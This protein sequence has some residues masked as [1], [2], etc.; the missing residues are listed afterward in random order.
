MP[1][2]VFRKWWFWTLLALL[3]IAIFITFVVGS[4]RER[5]ERTLSDF[6]ANARAGIVTKVEVRDTE[7]TYGLEGDDIT[8]ETHMEEGDAVREILRDAGLEPGDPGYPRIEISRTSRLGNIIGIIL[9]FVPIILILG[10]LYYFFRRARNLQSG[11]LLVGGVSETDPVCGRKVS[12]DESA[13]SSTFQ[14]I[15]YRF[16]S[17]EHKQEFDNDPVK[18]L[19]EK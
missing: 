5:Q 10:T 9:Q 17:A 1:Q 2:S 18:Y 6:I 15:T 7:I 13:G 19:L 12:P 8:Y 16:C 14:N 11:N 3:V 4:G